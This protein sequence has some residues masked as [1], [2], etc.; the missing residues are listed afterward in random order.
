MPGSVVLGQEPLP[1]HQQDKGADRG[2]LEITAWYS[3]FLAS[4]H[5][6]L[7]RVV[8]TTQYITEAELPA[9]QDLYTRRCQRKALKIVRLHPPMS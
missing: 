9:I 7:Q 3:N 1:Q 2:L 5:I 6:A 8:S 4:D